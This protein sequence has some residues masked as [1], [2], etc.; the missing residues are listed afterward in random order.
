METGWAE[1]FWEELER[2]VYPDGM[3]REA[4]TAYHRLVTEMLLSVAA[5]CLINEVELP[6]IV[7]ARIRAMLDVIMHY[8]QPDGLS[9][10]LG[11]SDDGRLLIVTVH[12]DPVRTV[13]DHRHLLALGSLIFERESI[14]WAGFVD[15]A[16]HGWSV[17]AG[18]EWQ[19][20]FW[21]F[22]SDAAA[23]YSDVLTR[24]T[25]RPDVPPD[26]WIQV[27]SGIRVRARALAR[28][29]I[30]VSE[31]T[32]SREFEAGGL[33]IMRH[34]DLHMTV[35][36][37]D[38]GQQGI[39]GHAHND[40]L[41]LTLCTHD[42]RFLI[43]P[44]SY[45]YTSDPS[46][47]NAF[48]STAYHNTLQIGS[49]EINNVPENDL[50]RLD[51]DARVILHRWISQPTYDLFDASHDGFARLNPHGFIVARYSST[52]T[53]DSGF[54]MIMCHWLNSMSRRPLHLHR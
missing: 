23:R 21:F 28:H 27:T 13:Q 47:R 53:R 34:E 11:D 18:P 33:Y 19:D 1:A 54:S 10:Q 29:P 52:R 48:R 12:S 50:F 14:D 6:E 20:A 44:G 9:P 26:E 3:S 22:T 37:G 36:A 2:Q 15:P 43:D 31:V 30:K 35:D 17:V 49:E 5:L 4:S 46:A 41:S 45:V 8:T 38:V 42:I 7:Q 25:A 16:E 24:V 40:T 32:S 39:A 51:G